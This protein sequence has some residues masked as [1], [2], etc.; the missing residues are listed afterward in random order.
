MYIAA[1]VYRVL[2]W[3][4]RSGNF[5][6]SD[7]EWEISSLNKFCEQYYIRH[8]KRNFIIFL[9]YLS[10]R[11]RQGSI[12]KCFKNCWFDY[13]IKCISS[14]NLFCNLLR[15]FENYWSNFLFSK[16]KYIVLLLRYNKISNRGFIL[17]N[18]TYIS[19]HKNFVFYCKA[20]LQ[21]F[22]SRF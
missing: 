7:N 15:L 18:S 14:K 8:Q 4:L 3:Q 9:C 2:F 19:W 21:N 13:L 22:F 11:I 10:Y 1:V 16:L 5:S 6:L 17:G 12:R 20:A